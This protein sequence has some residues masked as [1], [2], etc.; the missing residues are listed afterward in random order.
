[1]WSGVP[2]QKTRA[3][4]LLHLIRRRMPEG[5]EPPNVTHDAQRG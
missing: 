1:V 5:I 3:H 4:E 2:Q